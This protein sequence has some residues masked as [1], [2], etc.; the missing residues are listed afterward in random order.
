MRVL[1]S[2]PACT[3]P[4]MIPTP[5]KSVSYPS[6]LE[7]QHRTL[8]KR[9]LRNRQSMDFRDGSPQWNG[10][11]LRYVNRDGSVHFGACR[12]RATALSRKAHRTAS[13]A[14]WRD[15]LP[16]RKGLARMRCANQRFRIPATRFLLMPG[17]RLRRNA[18]SIVSMTRERENAREPSDTGQSATSGVPLP[19]WC[20]D[21]G[22]VARKCRG[23]RSLPN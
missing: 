7:R 13:L 14:L 4:L 12:D 22:H 10:R 5:M 20:S 18:V 19:V 1:I 17:C 16:F 21:D 9:T 6:S 8:T 3:R 15:C 23:S 2:I 11:R